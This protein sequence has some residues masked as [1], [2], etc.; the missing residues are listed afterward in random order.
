MNGDERSLGGERAEKTK[1]GMGTMK[2]RILCIL[3][4]DGNRR[5]VF[6]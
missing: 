2:W 4:R 6:E 3:F 5:I 1:E